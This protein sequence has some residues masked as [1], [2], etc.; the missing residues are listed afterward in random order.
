VLEGILEF[1]WNGYTYRLKALQKAKRDSH[2]FILMHRLF[3]SDKT[4]EI[5]NPNFLKL[6]Y[7][8]RWYYDILKALDYFQLAKVKYDHRMN[9]AIEIIANKRTKEGLWKLASKHPGQTHFEMEKSGSPSRWNTLR[10]LRV[11]QYYKKIEL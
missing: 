7:P 11:L 2:E 8:S 5:I 10:C 4:G 1:E 6:Y 9:D 3:R